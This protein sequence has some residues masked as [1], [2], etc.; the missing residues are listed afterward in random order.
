MRAR[1]SKSPWRRK[2]AAENKMADHIDGKKEQVESKAQNTG[3]TFSMG[4]QLLASVL[5]SMGLEPDED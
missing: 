4:G 2:E 1:N 5:H 3:L